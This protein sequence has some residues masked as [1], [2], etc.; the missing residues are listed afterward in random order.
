MK[1]TIVELPNINLIGISIIANNNDK[2]QNIGTAWGK[3]LSENISEK[4]DR[5]FGNF[6]QNSIV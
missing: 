3:Y 2:V 1:K 4:I 5:V 6:H